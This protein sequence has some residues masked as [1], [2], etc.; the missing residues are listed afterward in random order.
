M[1]GEDV[2]GSGLVFEGIFNEHSAASDPVIDMLL[3]P[4]A[5]NRRH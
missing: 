4:Q 3:S 2:S 5:A 1:R